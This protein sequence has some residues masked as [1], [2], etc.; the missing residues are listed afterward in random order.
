MPTHL[1]GGVVMPLFGKKEKE[2]DKEKPQ[3]SSFEEVA[4]QLEAEAEKIYLIPEADIKFGSDFIDWMKER[5]MGKTVVMGK[6][7]EFK[8]MDQTLSFKVWRVEPFSSGVVTPKTKIFITRTTFKNPNIV[9]SVDKALGILALLE[10][11]LKKP[12]GYAVMSGIVEEA[13]R[14]LSK[15]DPNK[16]PRLLDDLETVEEYCLKIARENSGN[17]MGWLAVE[18]LG[19]LHNIR[20]MFRG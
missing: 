11:T 5:L 19:E 10:E 2:D 4:R 15:L 1:V 16:I 18:V 13:G 3:S 6:R 7:L 20:K 8:V 17:A 14:D 9:T 12:S